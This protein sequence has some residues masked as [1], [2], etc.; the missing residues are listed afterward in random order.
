MNL[1]QRVDSFVHLGKILSDI[2]HPYTDGMTISQSEHE[3]ANDLIERVKSFNGWFTPENVKSQL[4]AISGWLEKS[5]LDQWTSQYP[6]DGNGKNIA[7]IMAGNIP[8]VGF[9]DLLS[10]LISGHSALVKMSSDD[11]H[12][13]PMVVD[14]WRHSHPEMTNKIEFAKGKLTAFDGVIATGSNNSA[15]Y[16]EQYFGQYPHII[17]KNRTSVALLTGDESEA[18]MK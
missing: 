7:I 13:L 8:L 1:E 12:L 4:K 5:Q 10:V 17:R 3:M 15:R 11:Q 9:H 16:F 14:L 6:S 18:E 2:L